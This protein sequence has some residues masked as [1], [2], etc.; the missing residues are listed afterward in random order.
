MVVKTN[1]IMLI[2]IRNPIGPYRY[3]NFASLSKELDFNCMMN[4]NYCY[5]SSYTS[6][7]AISNSKIRPDNT[8]FR[9]QAT[10][11]D[12]VISSISRVQNQANEDYDQR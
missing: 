3:T 2:K 1:K 12:V 5:V 7:P 4:L 9:A 10:S 11:K 6:K 8:V